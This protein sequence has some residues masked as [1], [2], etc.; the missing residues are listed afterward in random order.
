MQNDQK[1]D[2]R[3]ESRFS[4][5]AGG[6]LILLALTLYLLTLDNGLQPGELEGGDLITHQYAQVQARPGNAPGYPLYTM[7]GWLWFHTLRSVL[8]LSG[9]VAPNPL[10][11]LASYSTLWALLSLLLLYRIVCQLTRSPHRPAGHW[12]LAWLL[13][14]FYAV[15]YFFWYYATTTEQYSSAIAHTLAIVWLYLRWRQATG[16]QANRLLLLLALLCGLSLA[17]MLTVAFIVPPLVLAILWERP[18]L[19]RSV[20]LGIALCAA[21]L[22][23]LSLYFYV[24]LRG[25]AHPEWWGG[26][27]PDAQSWFWSFVSTAQGREELARGF[28]PGCG[29]FDGGFP[30]LIWGELGLPLLAVGLGGL[31]LLGRR[32]ASLFYGTLAIYLLFNW[33]YRCGNWYQVILPAY[34]LL[35]V[36]VAAAVQ[37]WEGRAAPRWLRSAPLALLALAV[38]WRLAAS[39]PAADSHNRPED[40]ALNRAAVLLDQP[41]PAGA[42]LFAQV[43]DALALDYLIEIWGIRPDLR[44]V[45]SPQAAAVLARGGSVLTATDAAAVLL[46][47]LPASLQPARTLSGPDWLAL[48]AAP[49][50]G[51]PPTEQLERSIE[52]A[53]TLAGYRVDPAPTG[54]P[55]TQAPPAVDVTLY[56]R[57]TAGWPPELGIS[58]RPTAQGSQIPDPATGGKIQ[59]DAATPLQGLVPLEPSALLAD[60]VRVPFPAGADGLLLIV[61]RKTTDGFENLLELPLQVTPIYPTQEESNANCRHR[62]QRPCGQ[63][64]GPQAG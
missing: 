13:T 22:L 6:L 12:P 52:Q 60:P 56:W 35:L 50:P 16:P 21:A 25:A 27:Y 63:L 37:R 54:S 3:Q 20:R 57:L 48:A 64:P 4:S 9:Q 15:T 17:H 42:A 10:P 43:N 45:S 61:Y 62:G 29:V 11:L 8:Q 1:I 28:Q 23:P 36:G 40:S 53:V 49:L 38:V 19:L 44:V 46:A 33:M 5:C 47:E 58:L 26:S 7:G 24:Y 55:V 41:L 31:A 34:P 18:Q 2:T 14:L 39:W 30:A 59:R 51:A 32:L